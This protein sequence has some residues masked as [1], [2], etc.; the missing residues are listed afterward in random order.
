MAK[1]GKGGTHPVSL[2][3]KDDQPSDGDVDRAERKHVAGTKDES[4]QY[5]DASEYEPSD[6]DDDEDAQR[7]QQRSKERAKFRGARPDRGDS[8][9]E[10][11]SCTASP[12]KDARQKATALSRDIK[13]ARD[14]TAQKRPHGSAVANHSKRGGAAVAASSSSSSAV[15]APSSIGSTVVSSDKRQRNPERLVNDL[16][17][18]WYGRRDAHQNLGGFGANDARAFRERQKRRGNPNQRNR[19]LHFP[20]SVWMVDRDCPTE[21]IDAQ[22]F[23]PSAK[24]P[25]VLVVFV[26]MA[27]D[28][29]SQA[30][31]HLC[32]LADEAIDDRVSCS[33][34]TKP[35][36]SYDG[37]KKTVHRLGR[38]ENTYAFVVLHNRWI[39]QAMF[40]D[41]Q[42]L[43]KGENNLLRFGTLHVSLSH[44]KY[45]LHSNEKIIC[46]G[47]VLV[48][49]S[50]DSN[51]SIDKS[52]AQMLAKW[53]DRETHDMVIACTGRETCA[54]DVWKYF[55]NVSGAKHNCPL[56]QPVKKPKSAVA[57]TASS[58]GD[59]FE[60][61]RGEIFACPQ[62]VFLYG[63]CTKVN[64]PF[65]SQIRPFETS[66][67]RENRLLE[68][69]VD[70]HEIPLW[71]T[72]PSTDL[73][74]RQALG[75]VTIKAIQWDQSPDRVLPLYI[76]YDHPT[77]KKLNDPDATTTVKGKKGKGDKGKGKHKNSGNRIDKDDGKRTRIQQSQQQRLQS[78]TQTSASPPPMQPPPIP[79]PSHSPTPRRQAR[80]ASPQRRSRDRHQSRS[81]RSPRDRHQSRSTRIPR[82]PSG[83]PGPHRIVPKPHAKDSA[84][85]AVATTKNVQ[86]PR[87]ELYR[88][89]YREQNPRAAVAPPTQRRSR[90]PERRPKS[91][92][93]PSAPRRRPSPERRPDPVPER[94]TRVRPRG[95]MA[96]EGVYSKEG[97]AREDP[98]GRAKYIKSYGREFR[99]NY[100]RWVAEAPEERGPLL[101]GSVSSEEDDI[102]EEVDVS[103]SIDACNSTRAESSRRSRSPVRLR[104]NSLPVSMCRRPGITQ[105]ARPPPPWKTQSRI[106]KSDRA[107]S[108]ERTGRPVGRAAV[109]AP[110][111]K[112][113]VMH[114]RKVDFK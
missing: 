50:A 41:H 92:V 14:P 83:S 105:H 98:V 22:I 8:S 48:R 65:A 102:I 73:R 47:I 88:D 112:Y 62:M 66:S 53:T 56:W 91:A 6:D 59:P 107:E 36:T 64:L 111:A 15:A 114:A 104:R 54:V 55:G 86:R 9:A 103:V 49:R 27:I 67:I 68:C 37:P 101:D 44:T 60:P 109:R 58:D 12:L 85:S 16:E 89:L 99:R 13:A 1:P 97:R 95:T 2:E 11:S 96:D 78:V 81:T 76:F 80:L 45:D 52:D 30:H 28:E 75:E 10:P 21:E 87:V 100:R 7:E 23:G 82:S 93:A 24:N 110:R 33:D 39:S 94:R 40:D 17:G 19:E 63:D 18:E 77:K 5:S 106:A 90:S 71:V 113:V 108:P 35:Q 20:Q 51:T 72:P 74:H 69:V 84:G 61:P 34:S 31:D 3:E 32:K 26:D 70:K 29:Q 25:H 42:G 46:M 4:A 38:E 43:H 79:P 57:T